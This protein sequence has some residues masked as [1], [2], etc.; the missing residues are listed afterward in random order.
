LAAHASRQAHEIAEGFCRAAISFSGADHQADDVTAV[1]VTVAGCSAM[2]Q[3]GEVAWRS[4]DTSF[5]AV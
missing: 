2:E 3:T 4:R 5:Q 1:V